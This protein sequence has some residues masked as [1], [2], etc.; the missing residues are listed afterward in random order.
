MSAGDVEGN[1]QSALQPPCRLGEWHV[2][3]MVTQDTLLLSD[4]DST[5]EQLNFEL[6]SVANLVV[7]TSSKALIQENST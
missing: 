2:E 1:V 3:I 5:H 4:R 7:V 6:S